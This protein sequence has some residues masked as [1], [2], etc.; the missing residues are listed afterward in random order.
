MNCPESDGMNYTA[1][2]GQTFQIECGVDYAG[3]DMGRLYLD[4]IVGELWLENCIETC[5]NMT[6]CVDV[7]LSGCMLPEKPLIPH[8]CILI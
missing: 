7:S 3:G 8:F 5:G 2:S 6:G 1:P 4:D